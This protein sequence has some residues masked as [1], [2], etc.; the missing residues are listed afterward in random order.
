MATLEQANIY[1]ALRQNEQWSELDESLAR[2]LLQDAEDYIRSVYDIRPNLT[3]EEQRIFDGLVCRL[4]SIFVTRP[5]QVD[6][7]PTIK[8]ESKEGAGFKRETEYNPTGS[9]PYPYITAALR[10][11]LVTSSGAS[12]LQGKVTA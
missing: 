10:P 7:V 1:N 12:V 9:D 3:M 6:A 8:R 4:A 2:A 11:F 5:P